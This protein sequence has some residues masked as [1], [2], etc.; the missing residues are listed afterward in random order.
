MSP[1]RRAFTLVELLVSIAIIGILVS[2][3][4]PAVQAAR[5]ASRRAQCANHLRQNTLA[6]QMYH[7]AALVLP[8]ANLPSTWPRQ[9]TWFGEVNYVTNQVETSKGLIAPFI[10]NNSRV[11]RCPSNTGGF[12]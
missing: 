12:R 2:L 5:E 6:V 1:M 7:D 11:Y 9:V 8:P 10:E 4:L 3:I